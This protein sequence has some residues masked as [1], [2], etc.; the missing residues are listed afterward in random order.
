MTTR[1]PLLQRRSLPGKLIGWLISFCVLFALLSGGINVWLVYRDALRDQALT[2]ETVSSALSRPL[3]VSVWNEDAPGIQAQIDSLE[4][5][6]EI[7]RARLTTEGGA[8]YEAG[9]KPAA[10]QAYKSTIHAPGQSGHADIGELELEGDPGFVYG[11]VKQQAL[12]ALLT[13]VFQIAGVAFMIALAMQRFVTNHIARLARHITN[14]TA[15]LEVPPLPPRDVAQTD[16]IDLLTY[17]INFMQERLQ[18]DFNELRRLQ[19]ELAGHRDRLEVAVA[20]RTRELRET[21]LNLEEAKTAAEA[22]NRAKSRF[23]AM[24]SHEIRTPLNGVVAMAE[25]LEH[26]EMSPDQLSMAQVITQ[27]SQALLTII[28]DILDFSKI[29]AGRFEI[30]TVSFSVVQVIESVGEL[31]HQRADEK[32]LALDIDL[33][34]ALPA[35]MLG[36]PT[37]LR[38]IALNLG[39]NAIKF[40]ETGSV[41]LIVSVVDHREAQ[42]RL[43]FEVVDTGIG[44]TGEQRE[45]LFT[46]FQQA[47]TSTSRKFGGTGLGL[48]LSRRL[49]HLMGGDIDCR[50]GPDAGSCFWFELPFAVEPEGARPAAPEVAIRDASIVVLGAGGPRARAIAHQL[51]AAGIAEVHWA[52]LAEDG[53]QLL[54]ARSAAQR[55]TVALLILGNSGAGPEPALAALLREP[56]QDRLRLVAVGSRGRLA[57]LDEISRRSLFATLT[58]PIQRARLWTAIAA[59]LGRATLER[60][61]A[62]AELRYAPPTVAEARAAGALVLV[63]DDNATNQVVIGRLL[64]RMGYAHEVAANGLE[65]LA[66]LQRGGHGALFTDF[67]MPEMDGFQLTRSIRSSERG[68]SAR[69]PIVA[70]TA[71]ALP[72][73][74]RVCLAAGMDDYLT[75]PIDTRELAKALEQRIPAGQRLRR[76]IEAGRYPPLPAVP[77]APRVDPA[78]FDTSRLEES[79]GGFGP[80]A[81]SFLTGFLRNVPTMIGKIESALSGGRHAEARSAAHFLRGE[82]GS[83]GAVRLSRLAA[84]IQSC[85]D[86][87][88]HDTALLMAGLLPQTGEELAVALG[89]MG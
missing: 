81:R 31:L 37:R 84:D 25:E 62:R 26:S 76:P 86:A 24:M 70:V 15:D 46:E 50:S 39:A 78:I 51:E 72:G 57:A 6:P 59:A 9:T 87:G 7:A 49:C 44:I 66:L 18:G 52:G 10:G 55:E 23:L 21:A 47:D 56:K 85:L 77:A 64:T 5:F 74:R 89:P 13:S 73:T 35:A 2:L 22:A 83:I 19:T 27:S 32:G 14:L 1:A 60:T 45:K 12:N 8:V 88:D 33:D 80:E 3:S 11:Q 41:T 65:A 58:P 68:G 48:A 42:C 4:R 40:T 63:A 28:N 29:E 36:D 17:G 71:D 30:E 67:H 79:F 16:E 53:L 54:H 82:A 38:Q 43:R 34:P 61:T 69:L 75:K 20:E